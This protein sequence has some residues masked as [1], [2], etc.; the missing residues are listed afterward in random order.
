MNGAPVLEWQA[1]E[2]LRQ[3]WQGRLMRAMAWSNIAGIVRPKDK[4]AAIVLSMLAHS[5]EAGMWPLMIVT[6]PGFVSIVPPFVI[7][8]AKISRQGRVYLD[9][10]TKGYDVIRVIAF[11]SEREMEGEF[12]KLADLLKLNDADRRE[13]FGAVKRWIVADYRIDP[14]TGE[15]EKAA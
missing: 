15:K 12:R 10:T 2:D 7:T 14:L 4:M 13:M 1:A 5:Y 8:C 3:T 9:M 11:A 6:F